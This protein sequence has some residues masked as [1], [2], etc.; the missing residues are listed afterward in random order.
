MNMKKIFL[1][2]MAALTVFSSC[3][4]DEK[5]DVAVIGVTISPSSAQT[6]LEGA[7]LPL[8]ATVQP[9]NATNKKVTWTSSS[10]ATATVSDNGLV[11]A[12]KA[13]MTT[14]TVTTVDGG[15][16]ASVAVTVSKPG[17][18]P[19]FYV[20]EEQITL[21]SAAAG[22]YD[23]VVESNIAWTVDVDAEAAAWCSVSPTSGNGNGT[24]TVT[25]LTNPVPNTERTATVTFRMD[26]FDPLPVTVK[27]PAIKGTL[28][29]QCL[30]DASANGGSGAWVDGYVS[31]RF[32]EAGTPSAIT[33]YG[34]PMDYVAG[35]TSP[36]D[37]RANTAAMIA[38]NIALEGSA[39][40][41]CQS[42]GEG[43]YLPACEELF[44]ISAFQPESWW[45]ITELLNGRS[46]AGLLYGNDYFWSSTE[47]YNNGGR[48][49]S[50]DPNSTENTYSTATHS[51]CVVRATANG[52]PMG[53]GVKS[54][55]IAAFFVWRP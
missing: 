26:A 35:A 53:Q 7:S 45:A 10:T 33:L 22:A 21:P 34:G 3:G 49:N 38:A 51:Q 5:S 40:K 28:C 13:G 24:V 43:W 11:T 6:L 17:P 12:L 31:E 14:I 18:D 16:T 1:L 9:D 8:T 2:V 32:G 25:A 23:I 15:K 39:I 42:L 19:E 30:W 27:Q 46:G 41:I 36:V 55:G 4:D 48:V 29:T 54:W 47:F 20:A 50:N 37:G 44:N 52:Y